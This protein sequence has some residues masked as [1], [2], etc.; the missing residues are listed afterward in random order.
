VSEK[1][2]L[3]CT[4][5]LPWTADAEQTKTLTDTVTTYDAARGR[6]LNVASSTQVET[7][8]VEFRFPLYVAG[9]AVWRGT[10]GCTARWT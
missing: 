7:K 3:G 4:V 6:V 9:G 10:T 8:S 1:L 2:G 5:D